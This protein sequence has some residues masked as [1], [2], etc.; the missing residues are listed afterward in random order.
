MSFVN[1]IP[2]PP[3]SW[4]KSINKIVARQYEEQILNE[5]YKHPKYICLLKTRLL[6]FI[7]WAS[8]QRLDYLPNLSEEIVDFFKTKAWQNI[9]FIDISIKD[10]MRLRKVVFE[11]DQYTCVYCKLTTN[12]LECDHVVPVSKG[13]GSIID[14]LATACKDCNRS[15]RNKNIDEFLININYVK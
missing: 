13:G 12:N 9:R 6:P 15:K 14:N 3:S 1:E 8:F 2:K 11:R 7:K 4:F 10:W 5:L